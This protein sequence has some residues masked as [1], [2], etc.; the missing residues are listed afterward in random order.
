MRLFRGLLFLYPAEF[1]DEYGREL[2]L[3]FADRRREERSRLGLVRMWLSA[4]AGIFQEAPKEHCHMIIQDIRYTFRM[5]RQDAAITTAAIVILALGIGSATLVFSLA[6]GLLLR[7]LAFADQQRI[8][9]VCEYSPIDP[10]EAT[11]ISYPNYAD[12]RARTQLL[13]DIAV[14]AGG[15]ISIY[16]D[17]GAERVPVGQ[18]SDGFFAVLGVSPVLG[19]T[20]T[21]TEY[22]AGGPR[23]ALLS[24]GLWQRRYGRDPHVLGQTI[25]TGNARATIIGVMPASLTLPDRAELWLPLRLNPAQ[26]PRTD[27][28]LHSLA[29]L[30]PGVS[31]DQAT[32][33]LRAMLDQI[34]RDN[35]AA[36]NHW[37][38]H[39][40]PL[41]EYLAGNYRQAVTTLLGA[42]GLLL[43]IACANVSN[44]LLVKAS[45]RRREMAV[46]TALGATRRR[47]IRQLISESA[48][49]G[50]MGGACGVLLAWAGIPALLSLV[51]IDIPRWMNFSIDG[52]VLG[53]ALALSLITSFGFGLA[54]AFGS[55]TRD[56][57]AAVKQG[58][59]GGSADSR[60]KFVRNGLVVLEVALSVTLLAGA[61]LMVRSFLALRSQNLGYRPE[62]VLSL[63]I[64]YPAKRYADGPAAR[65]MIRHVSQELSSLPGMV[66]V[67][68]TTGVP[69]NDGWGRIYTIEGRPVRLED[70]P[71]VNHVVIGPNYFRT[72]GISLL[73]GRDISESDFDTPVLIV[74]ESF[75]RR[76]W[77]AGGALGKRVRFGPPAANEPWNQIVGI[78]ADNRHGQFK[79]Q[80]RD[81]VYLAYNSN[82]TPGAIV[83][84]TSG[85]PVQAAKSVTARIAQVDRNIAVSH[86]Y[87]LEQI[88]DRVSWQDRFFTVLFGVF[89]ALALTLAAVGLYG[90]LAYSVTLQTHEI[91]IRM[92]L[93]ASAAQVRGAIVRNGMLLAG[94]GLA[95]GMVAASGLTRLLQTQ[96]FQV[97]PRDPV[98][99]IAAPAVLALVALAA[100]LLPARRA[101]RVDP[102]IALRHE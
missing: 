33:E 90:L 58:G 6:N 59:R 72:L 16:D 86:V 100:A 32:E 46:R 63:Q 40:V 98:T 38:I 54:P 53:F 77:A 42:V 20:F 76:Y 19:R 30:K 99:Y 97:S 81:T 7:P 45:A 18:V 52:R 60:Q 96:L 84:R 48:I 65:D 82:V 9:A 34:H 78:V 43:L 3:A 95:V 67:A 29:R 80:H 101:T 62:H 35:P 23:V 70:M 51:P 41:R 10:N 25:N 12:M 26:V 36:N 71:P 68:F 28:F 47:L 27:Y 17:R 85:D 74:T 24:E 15:A 69:M 37:N 11:Q 61:G 8:V 2:C 22:T 21:R 93:G 5:M 13:Q 88:L 55:F 66:S 89:A 50:L 102:V 44:L 56:L 91:G 83:M 1:R 94:I 31:I 64:S 14:Y 49:F 57:S 87:S 4:A 75:A 79:G 92:A 39:A 73:E